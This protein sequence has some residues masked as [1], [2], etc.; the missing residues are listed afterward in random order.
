MCSPEDVEQR[1]GCQTSEHRP[2]EPQDLDT[3]K[4]GKVHADHRGARES[5]CEKLWKIYNHYYLI[6]RQPWQDRH[7]NGSLLCCLLRMRS[8]SLFTWTV[9]RRNSGGHDTEGSD[10]CFQ[11]SGEPAL[12]SA[13]FEWNM[14]HWWSERSSGDYVV[15]HIGECYSDKFFYLLG[16]G[17]CVSIKHKRIRVEIERMKGMNTWLRSG[18]MY[19]VT[20]RQCISKQVSKDGLWIQ[21]TSTSYKNVKPVWRDE[22]WCFPR[23]DPWI[24]FKHSKR[25]APRSDRTFF[26]T[27]IFPFRLSCPH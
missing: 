3:R 25:T 11:T 23:I 16:N 4:Y 6:I 27:D 7:Y 2:P 19:K 21:K 12:A 13:C 10:T 20:E 1:A 26:W 22:D 5:R 14:S 8:E 9:Q 24:H 17:K 15:L 18:E